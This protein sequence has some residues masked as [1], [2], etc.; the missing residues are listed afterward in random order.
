MPNPNLKFPVIRRLIINDYA[1]FPGPGRNGVDHTF[2]PG[3]TVVVGINGIGKTTMLNLIYRL[4]VGP[5]D[6]AKGEEGVQLTRGM[7]TKQR[8]FDYFAKRD[9]APTKATATGEFQFGDRRLL[10]SRRLTDLTLINLAIDDIP[11]RPKPGVNLE[12]EIWR[13]S[14]CGRQYDFHLLV[15]SLFFFLEEKAPIVWEAEAQI[16][17]FRILFLDTAAATELAR[18]GYNIQRA[19]SRRRN[20]LAELN[21]YKKRQIRAIAASS[22]T[23]DVK[24]NADQFEKRAERVEKDLQDVAATA[25]ELERTRQS[26]RQKL[27]GFKLDL[28]E[29]SRALEFLHHQYF[30]SLFPSLPDIVRNVFLNLVGD[31]G[32]TVCGS[33]TPGLSSRFQKIAV[34]G[35]C[36]VCGSP[37]EQ[38]EKFETAAEFGAETIKRQSEEI[39]ELKQQISELETL[40]SVDDESYRSALR[41]RIDLQAEYDHLT[42][43]AQRLRRLLP[44]NE[45]TKKDVE[46]YI[47]VTEREIAERERDIASDTVNYKTRLDVLRI[48]IESIREHLMQYFSSYAGH[49]LAENCSLIYKPRRLRLGESTELIEYPTFAVQM[50]SAVSPSS[51]VTRITDTDVSESQKEFIDLAFRMAVLRAYSRAQ[52]NESSAMIVIE[53][54][55]ASLDS[56]FVENAGNMLRNWCVSTETGTNSV[57]A[58]CNLNR[59]NMISALLGRDKPE[60]EKP[61]SNWIKRHVMNLLEIAAPNAALAQHREHYQREFENS[62]ATTND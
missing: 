3:V 40:N 58:S 36:P 38:H 22:A 52:G 21:R 26:N 43:E 34:T 59:E 50:T 53:T 35:D 33:R 42:E 30:A 44:A 24:K 4:L 54:P 37:K 17:V 1:L 18:L 45:Q 39:A 61:S 2:E 41:Q 57:I 47:K 10:I 46:N 12:D 31:T 27:D 49:F 9:K 29:K 32:C 16:E 20:M 8:S 14:G 56:V 25:A 48:E 15:T 11:V 51:G 62:T 55:E 23:K 5:W 28:E 7:L 60:D 19:D 6:F 13:L